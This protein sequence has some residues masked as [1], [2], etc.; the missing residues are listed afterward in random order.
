MIGAYKVLL[1][2]KMSFMLNQNF[3]NLH[4]IVF[5]RVMHRGPAILHNG[6]R[7]SESAVKDIT[8]VIAS[9]LAP[10]R[11]SSFATSALLNLAAICSGALR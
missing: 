3:G 4:C 10:L 7:E 2:A 8:F 9:R 6:S 1:L 5:C 11:S